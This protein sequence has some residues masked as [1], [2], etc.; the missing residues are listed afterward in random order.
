MNTK[1]LT[2][3]L[4]PTRAQLRAVPELTVENKLAAWFGDEGILKLKRSGEYT[5]FDLN[6]KEAKALSGWLA[7]ALAKV[8]P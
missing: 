3:I 6:Y 7:D 8:H 1:V 2:D 4:I 5:T